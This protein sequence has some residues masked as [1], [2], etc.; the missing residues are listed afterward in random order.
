MKKTLGG[1]SRP[2]PRAEEPVF[3]WGRVGDTRLEHENYPP[4]TPSWALTTRI[5]F[6]RSTLLRGVVNR[7]GGSVST[8]K[9]GAP[10][11]EGKGP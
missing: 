1:A 7:W 6:P 2:F 11:P 10:Q 9:P 8:E 5:E 4:S 3:S